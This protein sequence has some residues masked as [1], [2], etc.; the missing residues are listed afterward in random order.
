MTLDRALKMVEKMP[1]E[2]KFTD[3][4]DDPIEGLSVLTLDR[5]AKLGMA[6][7]MIRN[8]QSLETTVRRAIRSYLRARH[9][10]QRI[11]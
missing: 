2:I 3:E 1:D 6:L 10:D 5:E 11:S 7:T 9:Q 4:N 8:K